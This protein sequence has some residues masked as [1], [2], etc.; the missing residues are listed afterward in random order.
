MAK[1]YSMYLNK[2]KRYSRK[3]KKIK[4]DLVC[5]LVGQQTILSKKEK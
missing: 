2:I 3:E 1:I 5:N 4:N